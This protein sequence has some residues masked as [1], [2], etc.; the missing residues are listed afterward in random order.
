MEKYI[1]Y[2]YAENK[3]VLLFPTDGLFKIMKDLFS[4]KQVI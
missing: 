1:L 2:I 4:S 3:L